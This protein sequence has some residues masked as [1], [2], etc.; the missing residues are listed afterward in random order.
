MHPQT[1]AERLRARIKAPPG[2]VTVWPWHEDDGR[3]MML[4][5][6]DSR[7]WV[8]TSPIPKTFQG[9]T[10]RVEKREPPI[11]HRRA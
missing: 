1:V 4:V 3:I 6:I 9:F 10:V 2:A 11:V 5:V 8:D 7:V